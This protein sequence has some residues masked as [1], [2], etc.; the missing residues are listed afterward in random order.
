MVVYVTSKNIVQWLVLRC[1][2]SLR[3]LLP[4]KAT[5]K[6]QSNP[7]CQNLPESASGENCREVAPGG[8]G[9][10]GDLV[11]DPVAP[12]EVG[13]RVVCCWGCD[14]GYP[15]SGFGHKSRQ[16]GEHNGCTHNHLPNR[17]V[18]SPAIFAARIA[19]SN[20]ATRW[21]LM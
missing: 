2:G 3:N 21:E 14:E 10:P 5:A 13:E 20:R 15:A 1:F 11:R 16:V 8:N 9:I 6:S 4:L 19:L 18:A 12:A 17:L 7:R